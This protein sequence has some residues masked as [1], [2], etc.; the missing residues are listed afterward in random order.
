ME[1]V[2]E[3]GAMDAAD[4]NAQLISEEETFRQMLH[5]VVLLLTVMVQVLHRKLHNKQNR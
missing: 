2:I 5:R 1:V 4:V 3:A